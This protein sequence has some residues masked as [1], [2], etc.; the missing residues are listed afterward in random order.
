M[1][2]GSK[3]FRNPEQLHKNIF[4]GVWCLKKSLLVSPDGST[5]KLSNILLQQK[6]EL[7]RLEKR[8]FWFWSV[9]IENGGKFNQ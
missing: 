8:V 3:P 6:A 5:N 1:T 9:E 7:G 2:K 4:C